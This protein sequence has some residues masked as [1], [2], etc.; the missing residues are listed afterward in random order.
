MSLNPQIKQRHMKRFFLSGPGGA[1]LLLVAG[2]L[3]APSARPQALPEPSLVLYG[4][5]RNQADQNTRITTGTLTWQIRRVSSGRAI[6][7]S[8]LLTNLLD[9]FS[10]VVQVPCETVVTG[11]TV[12]TN[13]LDLSPLPA[14][15]DRS[16]V[17]LGTNAV[18]FANPD[19][20][21]TLL[22]SLNRGSVE[23]VDLVVNLG[24]ID[25][26]GSG[27]PDEWQTRYFGFVGVDPKGDADHDGLKNVDEYRSGTNPTNAA[28]C[29][30]FIDCYRHPQ[31]GYQVEWSSVEGH[32]YDL[33]RSTSLLSGFTAIQTNLLAT[34]P[35]NAY[36]D[37]NAIGPSSFFYR[38]RLRMSQ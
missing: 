33:D 37:T 38:L 15:F 29:F 24:I 16:Q 4:I 1:F 10:Y 23:R 22:S 28:S 26:T 7:L 20:A 9:Q 31:G 19:Q 3:T 32:A 21:A 30:A 25:S 36:H 35:I 18:K 6:T 14:A 27:M 5:V 12:S 8:V 34:P 17:A 13:A 2:C 11:Y